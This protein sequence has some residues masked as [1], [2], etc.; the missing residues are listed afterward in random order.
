MDVA[1]NIRVRIDRAQA[2]DIFY[3]L[4]AFSHRHKG[5]GHR[6]GQNVKPLL[7]AGVSL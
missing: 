6:V 7:H 3:F 2:G 5:I 1:S 4:A